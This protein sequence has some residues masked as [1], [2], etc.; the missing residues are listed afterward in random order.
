MPPPPY[1]H[2]LDNPDMDCPPVVYI[3]EGGPAIE[4]HLEQD[5]MDGGMGVY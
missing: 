2:P 3:R 1:P 4:P 5:H